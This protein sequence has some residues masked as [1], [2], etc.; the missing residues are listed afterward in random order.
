MT[1]LQLVSAGAVLFIVVG[2][3]ARGGWLLTQRL[4]QQTTPASREEIVAVALV[5]FGVLLLGL[6]GGGLFW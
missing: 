5:V 1:Y 3:I 6:S 2:A 4:R